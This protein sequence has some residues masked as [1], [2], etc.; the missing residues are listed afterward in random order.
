M[1]KAITDRIIKNWK[2]TIVGALLLIFASVL[3]WFQKITWGEYV[4]FLPTTLGLIWSKDEFVNSIIKKG[5]GTAVIIVSLLL[6]NSCV[7]YDRCVEK[8]GVVR[9]DTVEVPFRVVIPHYISLPADS[10]KLVLNIDSIT[11][12]VAGQIYY[13]QD[14]VSKIRIQY[15]RDLAGKLLIRAYTPADTV[16]DTIIMDT[17]VHCPPPVQLQPKD[18]ILAKYKNFSVWAVPL[19]LVL[20][21]LII[22]IFTRKSLK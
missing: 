2:S 18:N 21:I 19:L 4:A 12:M 11:A 3:V 17:I 22:G 10:N 1:K 5:S 7:T 9:T 15:W 16:R 8:Y 6:M 13:K 20:L 14:S